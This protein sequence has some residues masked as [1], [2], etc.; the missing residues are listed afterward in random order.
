MRKSV[1]GTRVAAFAHRIAAIM[2]SD[3]PR[4]KLL[5]PGT[6]TDVKGVK[7]TFSKADLQQV[8]DSYDAGADPAPLVVGHP[9]LDTPAYGWVGKLS[10]QGDVLF[11]EPSSIDPGLADAVAAKQYQRISPSLYP[12]ADPNNPT[13][14]QWHLKHVG[15]LGAAT[16]AI[17]GLGTVAFAD[18]G[19]M[20][21]VD[22]DPTTLSPEPRMNEPENQAAVDFAER[23]AAIASKEAELAERETA[24]KVSQAQIDADAAAALVTANVA[25]AEGLINDGRLMPAGRDKVIVLLGAL[26]PIEAVS[27]GEGDTAVSIVPLQALK[28]ILSGADQILSFGES[29]SAAKGDPKEVPP[30]AIAQEAVAFAESERRAGRTITDAQA[31]RHVMAKKD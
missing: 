26:Q 8:V 22:I 6:F 27:F 10:L 25:F 16:P 13:P 11:A 3:T 29:A 17:K 2:T 5:R 9:K 31:V 18:A 19:D 24:L 28:D 23:E 21:T 30:T 7:V 1:R 20:V 4:I 15:F 12:P 14:G